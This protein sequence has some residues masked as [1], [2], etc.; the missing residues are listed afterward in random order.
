MPKNA[1]AEG[2]MKSTKETARDLGVT[3]RTVQ[4]WVKSGRLAG[5][6]VGGGNVIHE[7]DDLIR[8]LARSRGSDAPVIRSA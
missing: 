1:Y 8:S 5:E 6:R 7:D 4:R 2:D 3:T